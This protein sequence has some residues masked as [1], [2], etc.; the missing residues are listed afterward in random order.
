MYTKSQKLHCVY[1]EQK[2]VEREI[3]PLSYVML[4]TFDLLILKSIGV[5]CEWWSTSLPTLM[6]IG[7][8]ILKLS[9]KMVLL[10]LLT[11]KSI[12]VIYQWW[13]N[14]SKQCFSI[15]GHFDLDRWPTDLKK[16]RGHLPMMNNFP[17]KFHDPEPKHT[18]VIIRKWFYYFGSLWPCPLT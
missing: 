1:Y 2:F 5:I 4:M 18:Q 13:L 3:S 9:S 15:L 17:I 10:D 6:I 7:Q 11:S 12:G 16:D 8:N 14:D